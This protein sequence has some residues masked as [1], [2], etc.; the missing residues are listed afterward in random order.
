MTANA[1]T[2]ASSTSFRSQ[3]RNMA[4]PQNI[5]KV[6]NTTDLNSNENANFPVSLGTTDPDDERYYLQRQ[7]V[8]E[9]GIVP[10]VGQA[11]VGPEY[12]DYIKR[13]EEVAQF[14][15]YQGWLMKQA[16]FTTPE[17]AQY[18]YTH[19]P[20]MLQKRIEQV[21]RVGDLQKQVGKIQ[22]AGPQTE[23]DWKLLFAMH[24][25]L[26]DVPSV[27]PHMLGMWAKPNNNNYRHGMFSPLVTADGMFPPT[28]VNKGIVWNNPTALPGQDFQ[29]NRFIAFPRSTAE[30]QSP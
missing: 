4:S 12:F 3:L 7:L 1:G 11:I 26:V 29:V 22:V 25:N 24:K 19:H 5:F 27:A 14:A 18:W 17:K 21:D 10:K 23:D 28:A 6:S 16:D 30:Y 13:K 15:E 9:S 8:G 20:W 2:Q